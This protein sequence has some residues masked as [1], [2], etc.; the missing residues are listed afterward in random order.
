MGVIEARREAFYQ[1]AA[2][3]DLAP[4]WTV[5]KGLVTRRPESPA[6]PACWRFRDVR[7]FL[8]EACDLIGTEEAERRVL[9]LENPALHGQAKI[10]RSLYA[11]LQIVMP[12][13]VARAH[14]HVASAL[15]FIVEG[16]G[17]HTAVDGERTGMS[18]GDFVITPSWT[19]H[20]HGND[21]DE[22]VIWLDGLDVHIVNLLDSSFR[23]DEGE[24][25]SATTRPTGASLAE[26]ALNML[27]IDFDRKGGTSPIF[28]YPYTRTR[29]ALDGISRFRDPDPAF[30]FKMRYVNPTNGD[31]A[32]STIATWAQLVPKG[33]HTTPYRST[34]GTIFV[35]IEGEGYSL[36]G[37]TRFD[38]GPHDIF[39][40]PSWCESIHIGNAESILFGI[41][42]RVV[43]EKLGLWRESREAAN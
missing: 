26:A 5:L 19:W 9:M 20:E 15:R 8:I 21:G 32:I 12:G 25:P 22:P 43:Q 27:P 1:R 7:P 24:R 33:F 10:T 17:G 40:V 23:E 28:N 13:E 36:I 34:D 41:S 14:R 3:T 2:Q 35:V 16:S 31:W 42:D 11:G 6:V 39:V 37:G 29:E 18:P 4:L 30:G 38:W